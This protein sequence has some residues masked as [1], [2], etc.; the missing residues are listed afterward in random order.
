MSLNPKDPQRLKNIDFD[1]IFD[2]KKQEPKNEIPQTMFESFRNTESSTVKNSEMESSNLLKNVLQNNRG[3]I[4]QP[5]SSANLDTH[6]PEFKSSNRAS[7]QPKMTAFEEFGFEPT[8]P[9]NHQIDFLDLKMDDEPKVEG[10]GDLDL[11][12]LR[13]DEGIMNQEIQDMEQNLFKKELQEP[14]SFVSNTQAQLEIPSDRGNLV[15]AQK[16]I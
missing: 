8:N 12:G 6:A 11:M 1:N 10:E 4:S 15:S 9:K 7:I 14:E 13:V 16:V 2:E 5:G 3:T